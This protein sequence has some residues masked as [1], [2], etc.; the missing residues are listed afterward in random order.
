MSRFRFIQAEKATYPVVVLCRALEVS[1]AGYY[2]WACR[3]VSTRAQADG[4]LTQQIRT[5]HE[6]SRGTYGGPPGAR[7]AP[8]QRPTGGAPARGA[9]DASGGVAR[10]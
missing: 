3:G 5:I 7:R 6:G 2:A 1:R 9:A 4:A 10:V 8:R